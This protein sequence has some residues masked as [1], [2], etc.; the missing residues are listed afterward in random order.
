MPTDIFEKVHRTLHATVS[1]T[2]QPTIRNEVIFSMEI[3]VFVQTVVARCEKGFSFRIFS[4]KILYQ[5]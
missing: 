4:K 5:I 3:Y 1:G 2:H